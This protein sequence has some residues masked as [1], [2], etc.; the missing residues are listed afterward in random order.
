MTSE[1]NSTTQ[2][3]LAQLK[4][5]L[6]SAVDSI[7]CIN[8]RGIIQNVNPA[9]TKMFGYEIDDMVGQNISMLMPNPYAREHD[10]YLD[11]YHQTR[12]RHIIGI[13]REVCGKRKDGSTFPID[14]AVSESNAGDETF[15]TGVIRDLTERHQMEADLRVQ[16][17]ALAAAGQGVCVLDATIAGVVCPIRSCNPAIERITGYDSQTLVGKPI[18]FLVCFDADS[19]G[20]KAE[21]MTQSGI[22]ENL[23][24]GGSVQTIVKCRRGDDRREYWASLDISPIRDHQG[25]VTHHVVVMADV[26]DQQQRQQW[27]ERKVAERTRQLEQTQ[28]QLVQQEKLAV[29]GRVSGS[30][31]HEIRNPLNA[32]KTSAYFL[33]NARHPAAE[34]TR[35]H[36]QRI[37]RQVGLINQVITV[38]SDAAR[39][40]APIQ[41]PVSIQRI[42]QDV[43]EIIEMPSSIDLSTRIEDDLPEVW[44]DANQMAIVLRNLLQNAREAMGGSGKLSIS[45]VRGDHLDASVELTIADDGIGIAEE[46]LPRIEEPLFSTKSAGMGLGLSISSVILK[47]NHCPMRV[48][49]KVGEGSSFIIDLPTRPPIMNADQT[50]VEQ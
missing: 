33:L 38:L 44:V 2:R 27:L 18:T 30:I 47:Q 26:T 45:A 17:R 8:R 24:V 40:P 11:R 14:L 39:M 21:P 28:Q 32:I 9:A 13:G 35:D 23:A 25:G 20:V 34:K 50:E 43:F 48:Q 22:L 1:T 3:E 36:L 12:Q 7:I 46:I 15:Y 19:S 5:I 16:S 31:A 41:E 6:N 37:D 29:L 42:F 4:A 49:S 10:G